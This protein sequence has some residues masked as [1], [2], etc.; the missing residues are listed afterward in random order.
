MIGFARSEQRRGL[1]CFDT[2]SGLFF[3]FFV[4]LSRDVSGTC[5]G[6]RDES[7]LGFP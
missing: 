2:C 5:Y 7:G 6:A 1:T 4:P 3:L